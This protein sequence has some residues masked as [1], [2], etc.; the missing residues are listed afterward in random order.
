M[1]TTPSLARS[2]SFTRSRVSPRLVQVSGNTQLF[3]EVP[4]SHHISNRESAQTGNINL[5]T[6]RPFVLS[7]APRS[8]PHSAKINTGKQTASER[9]TTSGGDT[10][11]TSWNQIPREI[12][13]NNRIS[14]DDTYYTLMKDNKVEKSKVEANKFFMATA[15]PTP[16]ATPPRG[17]SLEEPLT[18]THT[19]MNGYSQ[20]GP[21]IGMALGSPAHPQHGWSQSPYGMN[22]IEQPQE[23]MSHKENLSP[24]SPATKQKTKWKGF[25]SLFGRKPPKAFY[26]LDESTDSEQ[27]S[28]YGNTAQLDSADSKLRGR[29]NTTSRATKR[30]PVPTRSNTTPVEKK[31]W[32]Q[33]PNRNQKAP[34]I[35]L[36]GGPMLDVEIPSIHLDRY[37]VMFGGVLGK[38]GMDTSSSLLARR[39]ATLDKLKTVNEA[40]AEKVSVPILTS[41]Y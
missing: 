21:Q 5:R 26:Q 36:D 6:S 1:L 24:I 15:P 30:A 32:A 17:P 12:L 23:F 40:I 34:E 22:T 31:A 11:L 28:T 9:P 7:Q 41:K 39:Q 3:S 35:H 20:N 27:H 10:A 33:K 16:D 13:S 8:L 38:A 14:R 2:E 18:G 29:S 25:G 4:V 19:E 37:S